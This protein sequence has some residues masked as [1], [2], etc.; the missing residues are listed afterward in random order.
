MFGANVGLQ[1]AQAVFW[2]R[3]VSIPR[4]WR[5]LALQGIGYGIGSELWRERLKSRG[6]GNVRHSGTLAAAKSGSLFAGVPVDTICCPILEIRNAIADAPRRN[7]NVRRPV[8]PPAPVLKGPGCQPERRSR[9]T[10]AEKNCWCACCL[11]HRVTPC[12]R[13]SIPHVVTMP[14]TML[15]KVRTSYA[16]T[17]TPGPCQASLHSSDSVESRFAA[18]LAGRQS[19]R[20]GA[21]R[22]SHRGFPPS[23]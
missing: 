3:S 16:T 21:C 6:T 15:S 5:F 23:T 8:A 10:L 22:N 1:D 20:R 2:W 12:W 7:P 9:V 11:I 19:R 4:A 18:S 17:S 14:R 13:V